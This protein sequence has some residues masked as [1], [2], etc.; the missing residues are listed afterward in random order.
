MFN[1][2]N[3]GSEHCIVAHRS[4][5]LLAFMSKKTTFKTHDALLSQTIIKIQIDPTT[6]ENLL[7]ISHY[8][9]QVTFLI[10]TT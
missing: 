7:V 8:F 3:I 2:C 6:F 9:Y 5:Q 1:C 4:L 10:N